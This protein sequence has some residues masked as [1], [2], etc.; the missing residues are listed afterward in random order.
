MIDAD[1]AHPSR[2]TP[3]FIFIPSSSSTLRLQQKSTY[4]DNISVAWCTQ[5]IK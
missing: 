1:G 2:E 3:C 5:W 4:T